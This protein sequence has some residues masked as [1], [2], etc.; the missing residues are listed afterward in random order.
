MKLELLCEGIYNNQNHH[1]SNKEEMAIDMLIKNY[2][3]HIIHV[4]VVQKIISFARSNKSYINPQ[5]TRNNGPDNFN[6]IENVISQFTKDRRIIAIFGK[7]DVDDWSK[8]RHITK[9]LSEIKMSTGDLLLVQ[10]KHRDIGQ[11]IVNNFDGSNIIM[12]VLAGL[13]LGYYPSK[14]LTWCNQYVDDNI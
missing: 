3:T 10:D 12:H 13:S 6:I 9:G 11:F 8:L 7:V 2:L 14:V 1:T 5:D 4:P